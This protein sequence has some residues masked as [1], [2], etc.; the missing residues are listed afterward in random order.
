MAKRT[1]KIL[2]FDGGINSDADPRDI[3]DNQLA[4]LQNVAIDEMGKIIVLGDCSIERITGLTGTLSLAGRGLFIFAADYNGIC[5]D[6]SGPKTYYL[7][8]HGNLIVGK[9]TD[10]TDLGTVITFSSLGTACYY[11]ADGVLRV[12]DAD[13]SIATAP[14]WKG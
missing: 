9:Q 12:G 7:I 13:H 8:E 6:T 3:G 10:N 11:A 5:G 2:R 14:K 4:D 1:Y